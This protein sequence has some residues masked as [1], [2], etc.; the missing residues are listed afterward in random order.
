[1]SGDEDQDQDKQSNPLTNSL[2]V[3]NELFK[4]EDDIVYDTVSVKR[5]SSTRHGEN[6]DILVNG[7]SS[8]KL[9]GDRFTKKEKEFLRTPA[10]VQFVIAEF[11]NGCSSINKFKQMM[12]DKNDNTET[13]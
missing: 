11:K 5:T 6:W 1:M 7:K 9:K 12:R 4:D 2:R 10:G 13:N 8:L 3:D